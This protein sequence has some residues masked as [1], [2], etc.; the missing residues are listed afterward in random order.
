MLVWMK[1]PGPSIERSTWLSAA[2][3]TMQVGRNASIRFLHGD[4]IGDVALHKAIARVVLDVGQG[5]AVPG[6][7]QQVEVGDRGVAGGQQVMDEI[8]ADEAGAA[9]DQYARGGDL[10][11]SASNSISG[12]SLRRATNR[13]SVLRCPGT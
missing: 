9:C 2:K 1:A 8:A 10:G 13:D 7:G 12:V 11:G 4:R 6:I 5:L 3:L